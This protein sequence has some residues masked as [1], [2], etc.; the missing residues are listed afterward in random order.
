MTTNYGVNATKRANQTIKDLDCHR[1]NM[2]SSL[3]DC[4]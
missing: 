3:L 2:K 4:L 1:A